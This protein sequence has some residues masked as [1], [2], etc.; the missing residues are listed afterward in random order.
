MTTNSFPAGTPVWI[1][2]PDTG[3]R[4]WMEY[5]VEVVEIPDYMLKNGRHNF[6][7]VFVKVTPDYFGKL[8]SRLATY[9]PNWVQ[10]AHDN[11]RPGQNG[12]EKV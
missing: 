10:R 3:V 5:D 1:I 6:K 8:E 4:L 12:E 9:A 11:V 2:N 7:D